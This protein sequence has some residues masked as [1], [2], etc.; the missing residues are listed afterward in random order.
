MK[1]K[2]VTKSRISM[3]SKWWEWNRLKEIRLSVWKLTDSYFELQIVHV[4]REVL[5]FE[6]F[7]SFTQKTSSLIID[8]NCVISKSQSSNSISSGSKT[9]I[10]KNIKNP[11]KR[12]EKKLRKIRN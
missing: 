11:I 7:R 4:G 9:E 1:E 5:S 10:N 2:S 3:F 6:P 8:V 12:S